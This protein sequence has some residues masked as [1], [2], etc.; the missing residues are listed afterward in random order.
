[1]NYSS[2]IK[3]AKILNL[4]SLKELNESIYLTRTNDN[5]YFSV[6]KLENNNDRAVFSLGTSSINIQPILRQVICTKGRRSN[7]YQSFV[8][9]PKDKSTGI[10]VI[11]I[12]LEEHHTFL[13]NVRILPLSTLSDIAEPETESKL[14]T[15]NLEKSKCVLKT[16]ITITA[17][18]TGE[19]LYAVHDV[20]VSA[21]SDLVTPDEIIE[22]KRELEFQGSKLIA[23][24]FQEILDIVINENPANPGRSPLIPDEYILTLP[25]EQLK[26]MMSANAIAGSIALEIIGSNVIQNLNRDWTAAGAFIGYLL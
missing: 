4:R 12:K 13:C 8:I 9:E 18:N 7:S 14:L 10:A 15:V 19:A 11:M 2:E 3:P 22:L 25:P 5:A 26:Q 1:M 16:D 23:H 24:Y 20:D 21:I 6:K 17:S